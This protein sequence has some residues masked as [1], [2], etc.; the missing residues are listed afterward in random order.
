MKSLISEHYL[1]CQARVEHELI[2][3]PV[4]AHLISPRRFFI[5]HG[6][7]LG[8]GRI[9]HYGGYRDSIKPGSI[10]VT[11]L[12]RFADSRPVWI[13]QEPSSYSSEEVV[14]RA[15][16]RIGE[17]HYSIFFNNCEH[18][19]NWCTRGKSYSEQ[20]NALI[21]SP[22]SFFSMISA[23]ESCFFA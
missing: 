14:S 21:H 18:F 4:G 10:E 9:A 12:E 7:Y 11:D 22:R 6:I 23:L 19:C 8:G 5:H 13:L 16:S 20:I 2:N 1:S 3:F 17:C 15:H